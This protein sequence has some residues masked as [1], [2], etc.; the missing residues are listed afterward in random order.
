MIAGWLQFAGL[1]KVLSYDRIKIEISC[2][3]EV[4]VG[5]EA[6]FVVLLAFINIDNFDTQRKQTLFKSY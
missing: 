2:I 6:R 5:L 3:T 4:V 1:K